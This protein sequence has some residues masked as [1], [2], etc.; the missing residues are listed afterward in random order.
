MATSTETS[1]RTTQ[2]L[3]L[4]H[5]HASMLGY[6]DGKID[7]TQTDLSAVYT[8]ACTLTA[9]APLWGTK[10]GQEKAVP[11]AEVRQMLAGML[12]YLTPERH[13]MHL[14]VHPNEK[15]LALYFVVKAKFRFVPCFAVMTVPLVFLV[16]FDDNEKGSLR[17]SEIHEWPAD[18]PEGGR[19]LLT[20]G[21]EWPAATVFRKYENFGALS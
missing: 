14:A 3:D 21:L 10:E 9:H 11:V 4:L 7:L 20:E 5:E 12:S 13:D 17:I 6:Y 18:S 2:L 1:A 16:S 15:A 8:S 19:Q